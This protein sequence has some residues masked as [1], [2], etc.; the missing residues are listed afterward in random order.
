MEKIFIYS[1]IMGGVEEEKH[2]E[3]VI[4]KIMKTIFKPH[5]QISFDKLKNYNKEKVIP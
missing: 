2:F 3:L 1:E 4:L 5:L